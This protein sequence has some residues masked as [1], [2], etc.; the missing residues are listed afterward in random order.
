MYLNDINYEFYF[1]I[2]I[3]VPLGTIVVFVLLTLLFSHSSMSN[4]SKTDPMAVISDV[5]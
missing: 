4:I 2:P 5:A 3:Y 1:D